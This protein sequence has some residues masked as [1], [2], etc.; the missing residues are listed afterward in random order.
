MKQAK[1][2]IR[3][4]Y[5]FINHKRV[6]L[7]TKTAMR[8]PEEVRGGDHGRRNEQTDHVSEHVHLPW[9]PTRTS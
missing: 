2:R 3:P 7:A 5:E 8:R 9:L 6:T 4:V 1:R